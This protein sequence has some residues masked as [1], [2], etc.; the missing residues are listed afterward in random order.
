[1]VAAASGADKWESMGMDLPPLPTKSEISAFRKAML[2]W[3]E[4]AAGLDAYSSSR[5]VLKPLIVHCDPRGQRGLAL[6]YFSRLNGLADVWA[7]LTT[8]A[9]AFIGAKAGQWDA[10]AADMLAQRIKDS[11]HDVHDTEKSSSWRH[12]VQ[13]TVQAAH[14]AL[15]ADPALGAYN[16]AAHAVLA[17]TYWAATAAPSDSEEFGFEAGLRE[18]WLQVALA[19][20][21]LVE[22]NGGS[23]LDL[24]WVEG[25]RALRPRLRTR[26]GNVAAPLD[27][28]EGLAGPAASDALDPDQGPHA[29]TAYEELANALVDQGEPASALAVADQCIADLGRNAAEAMATLRGVSLQ[30]LGRHD[31]AVRAFREALRAT[32]SAPEAMIDLADALREAGRY[33]EAR[34]TYNRLLRD[35]MP[36]QEQADRAVRG[37]QLIHELDST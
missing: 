37:L 34:E 6:A 23:W 22:S 28:D 5:E 3:V 29:L 30:A 13:A 31:E 7:P 11:V 4:L 12:C 9:E 17:I 21:V 15:A 36:E 20:Q 35:G 10:A 26:T 14:S 1:M 16:T 25:W 18:R 32:P 24:N 27:T 19:A 33:A 2:P 8:E